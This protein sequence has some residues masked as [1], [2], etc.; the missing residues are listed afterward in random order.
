M[1]NVRE[2]HQVL[3]QPPMLTAHYLTE[4]WIFCAEEARFD[5]SPIG[6]RQRRHGCGKRLMIFQMH[7]CALAARQCAAGVEGDACPRVAWVIDQFVE[8]RQ[9]SPRLLRDPFVIA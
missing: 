1:P 3:V 2:I 6:A 7:V 9:Q 5:L 4:E 8:E